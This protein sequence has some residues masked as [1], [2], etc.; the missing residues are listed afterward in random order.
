MAAEIAQRPQQELQLRGLFAPESFNDAELTAEVVWTAGARVRRSGWPSDY[1]EELSLAPGHV[2]LDRLNGGAPLLDSHNSME[3]SSVIGVVESAWVANGEG[4]AMVRFSKREEVQPIV[5]DV[6]AGILRNVSV[7]YRIHKI[8]RDETGEV[9]V[10]RAIDWEPYELSLVPIPADAGAQVRSNNITQ[11][12]NMTTE[13]NMAAAPTEVELRKTDLKRFNAIIDNT[14]AENRDEV[15]QLAAAEGIEAA[16]WRSLDLAAAKQALCPTQARSYCASDDWGGRG[17]GQRADVEQRLVR[18][19]NGEA[20]AISLMQVLEH[21]TGQRGSI[22][23]LVRG[24][25]ATT[26]FP[27]LLGSAG[28][29]VLREMYDAAPVG[30]RNIARR[31]QSTDLRDIRLLGLSEFPAMVKILEGGE[32][33]SGNLTDRGGSYRIEEYGRIVNLTRRALLQ[34][35]LDA[36]G[37]ALRSHGRAIAALEDDLVIAALESGATGAKCMEDGVALFHASHNNTTTETGLTLAS[38]TEAT[39]KLREAR[40]VGNGRRLNLSPRWLLV[41]AQHEVTAIQLTSEI[42]AAA[43]SD[44]NPFGGGQLALMPLVD[45]NLSGSHAYVLCDPASPAAAIEICTGP[46]VADVQ[47]QADFDTTSVKTRVL[48]DRGLGVR[49][50]RGIVR[51]PLS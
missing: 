46:A 31:R 16:Y 21:S 10:E 14:P 3:L 33:Q 8:E 17:F 34:D 4:R 1:L 43:A 15:R 23:T 7:G 36:F 20:S 29:Q 18:R 24:A 30:A 45:A 28:F 50:H 6:Q 35:M 40:E 5:R 42:N 32:F 25:M 2:R 41:S 26:D 12:D 19:L 37:E 9:P 27:Q 51:I 48:A 47:S 22:E 13:S 11:G 44:V 49:D 38:L 39:A